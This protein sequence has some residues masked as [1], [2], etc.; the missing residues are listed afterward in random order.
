MTIEEKIKYLKEWAEYLKSKNPDDLE[1]TQ[2]QDLVILEETIKDL[3]ALET[4][5]IHS[6]IVID[7][8]NK[9]F[10]TRIKE[11]DYLRRP[12]LDFDKVKYLAEKRK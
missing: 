3:E 5:A 7:D 8:D 4:I 12:I 6:A 9:Y 10:I 2:K 11:Y 1:P